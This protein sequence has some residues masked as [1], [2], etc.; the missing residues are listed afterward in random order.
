[1]TIGHDL[2]TSANDRMVSPFRKGFI[3]MKLRICTGLS[4]ILHAFIRKSDLKKI[5]AFSVV[6]LL[7][8]IDNFDKYASPGAFACFC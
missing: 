4:S 2:P 5:S 6:T 7:S 8:T 1:M 3:F